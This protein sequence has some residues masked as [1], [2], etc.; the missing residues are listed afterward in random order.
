M[1]R[2][3]MAISPG[4][5]YNDSRQADNRQNPLNFRVHPEANKNAVPMLTT[6]IIVLILGALLGARTLGG[7]VRTGCG[8]IIFVIVAIIALI[9]LLMGHQHYH[10][11]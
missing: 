11:Y 5:F 1:P 3:G 2:K 8:F 7:M 4:W 6:L 10:W 9:I